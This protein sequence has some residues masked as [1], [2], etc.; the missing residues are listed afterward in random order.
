MTKSI[1]WNNKLFVES[2]Y[3]LHHIEITNVRMERLQEITDDDIMREG[4]KKGEFYNTWDEYYFYVNEGCFTAKTPR[5][6]YA[7]II[8]KIRGKGTWE[9]NPWVVVY[10]F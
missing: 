10:E 5:E 2:Q 9:R 6:A 4:I 8:D 3:M 7:A 1:G